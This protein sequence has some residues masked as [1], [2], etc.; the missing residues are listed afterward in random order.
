M[1]CPTPHKKGR[2]TTRADAESAARR[3]EPAAGRPL[4]AYTCEP[5]CGWWHLTSN[6]H[7]PTDTVTPIEDPAV[8]D[9]VTHMTDDEFNDLTVRDIRGN[10]T[11]A[12]AAALRQP[13]LL[14]RWETAIGTFQTDLDAQFVA[15]KG[16]DS[17][18][19]QSWRRR[20]SYL[21]G[22]AA[23]RRK[24][25]RRLRL[26][27]KHLP[28]SVTPRPDVHRDPRRAAFVEEQLRR[29]A[30]DAALASAGLTRPEDKRRRIEAGDAAIS[31]LIAA[32]RD[33][34]N[35]ILTEEFDRRGVVTRRPRTTTEP[36][37]A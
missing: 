18:K 15:R 1:Q 10:V 5:G 36:Q 7:R 11:P 22:V 2:Y 12:E 14:H 20:A 6:P 30:N 37:A 8:T 23:A 29:A 34:F 21:R 24:E 3:R 9:T 13:H 19:A 28:S 31:R 17:D 4:T 27:H 16:D 26:E 32:H 33:E 25:A 35:Q